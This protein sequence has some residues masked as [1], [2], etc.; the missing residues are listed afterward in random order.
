VILLQRVGCRQAK[1]LVSADGANSSS[2]LGLLDTAPHFNHLFKPKTIVIRKDRGAAHAA[3]AGE[4]QIGH[5]V[6]V[7]GGRQQ[8]LLL[9][10]S[11]P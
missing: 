7:V 3:L 1:R 9:S 6:V 11:M 5:A 2:S 8:E 10:K 4:G